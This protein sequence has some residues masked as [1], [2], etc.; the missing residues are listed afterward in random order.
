MTSRSQAS[1]PVPVI[2]AVAHLGTF[3]TM[4]ESYHMG[5]LAYIGE[6]QS[7]PELIG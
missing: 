2:K 5:Q 4:H 3:L 6:S 7:L 1:G